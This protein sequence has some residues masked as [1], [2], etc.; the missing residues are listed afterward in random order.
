MMGGKYGEYY[1]VSKNQKTAMSNMIYV[2]Q[3]QEYMAVVSHHCSQHEQ[4]SILMVPTQASLQSG[5]TIVIQC[6]ASPFRSRLDFSALVCLG[7]RS[8]GL[9][10]L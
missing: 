5:A 2:N 1:F 10:P 6:T 8:T 7:L 4:E 3:E 9:E